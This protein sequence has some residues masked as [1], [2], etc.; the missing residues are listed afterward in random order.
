MCVFVEECSD[1]QFNMSSPWKC[2]DEC[3]YDPVSEVLINI[4]KKVSF[5]YFCSHAL[6]IAKPFTAHPV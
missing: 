5:I 3:V 6:I 1:R 2:G 4:K